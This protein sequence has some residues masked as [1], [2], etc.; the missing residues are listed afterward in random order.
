MKH[1]VADISRIRAGGVDLAVSVSGPE[2]GVPVVVLHGFTGSAEAMEL[3]RAFSG[4][5]PDIA[6]LLVRRG[7]D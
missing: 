3:Y 2:Q 1:E 7:L 4:R 5:E 6:P